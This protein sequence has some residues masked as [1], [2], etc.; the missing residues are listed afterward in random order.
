MLNQMNVDD[1]IKAAEALIAS[2]ERQQSPVTQIVARAFAAVHVPGADK[3]VGFLEGRR[4]E[5]RELLISVLRDELVRMNIRFDAL[6]EQHEHFLR[7]DLVELVA[8]GLQKAEDIR[9]KERV[10]WLGTILS[11]AVAAGPTLPPDETEEM[12]RIARDLDSRDVLILRHVVEFSQTDI[13]SQIRS[14]RLA[15]N[16]MS[17]DPAGLM[18]LGQTPLTDD[19]HAACLKL[20]SFG[21]VAAQAGST[22]TRFRALERGVRFLQYLKQQDW[23]PRSPRSSGGL[24][25]S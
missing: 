21:L 15:P 20:Q 5:N 9:D 22:E 19:A 10:V 18:G 25:P 16:L 2:D 3:I 4:A 7:T 14:E 23:E 8:D 17:N 12:M 1:P 24:A 6:S 13:G 11:T